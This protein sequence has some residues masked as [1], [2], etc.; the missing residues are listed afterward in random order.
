M[1][2][3]KLFVTTLRTRG[4]TL[5]T[6]TYRYES[7]RKAKAILP[8]HN[9]LVLLQDTIAVFSVRER[10]VGKTPCAANGRS[11]A[12]AATPPTG[13]SRAPFGWAC[14]PPWTALRL[15]ART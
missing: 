2:P 9:E 15:L 4:A 1:T 5:A 14:Q 7:V 10:P 6:D 12:S 8:H 3:G 13:R 11:L